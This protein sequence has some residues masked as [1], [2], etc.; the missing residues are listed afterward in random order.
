MFSPMKSGGVEDREYEECLDLRQSYIGMANPP[1]GFV[2]P[3]TIPKNAEEI[4]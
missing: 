4:K 2:L 3:G 1:A